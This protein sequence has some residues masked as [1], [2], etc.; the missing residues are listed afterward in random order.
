MI[1]KHSY[2]G[3][4]F[5]KLF[6]SYQS[7][8][9]TEKP[10]EQQ[11]VKV[12]SGCI[13]CPLN[14]N[15]SSVTC[16]TCKYASGINYN[17]GST[18]IKCSYQTQAKMTKEASSV[19]GVHWQNLALSTQETLDAVHSDM[20]KNICEELLWQ[21]REIGVKLAQSDLNEFSKK[22]QKESLYG[23]KLEKAARAYLAQF[24]KS[25][26][27]MISR[28]NSGALDDVFSMVNTPK[29]VVSTMS[30]P[31][32][33]DN[34]NSGCGYLGSKKNPN[35]IW[36]PDEISK[37]AQIPGTDERTKQLKEKIAE[38]KKTLKD[39][40]LKVLK[41]KLA[42]SELVSNARVHSTSTEETQSFNSNLPEN[43]MGIFGDHKEFEN[44]P[45]KTAGEQI[46]E[47]NEERT[48]KKAK[49]NATVQIKPAQNRES[50][51]WLFSNVQS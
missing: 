15:V 17:Q 4:T 35:T 19:Q 10:V 20:E 12:A 30:A 47:Q 26:K 34:M 6:N 44:I 41:E 14:G 43:A 24:N 49:E 27:P 32:V 40:Y 1:T 37:T 51:N 8:D 7:H 29:T 33:G 13:S 48:S 11:L 46:S 36:N 5:D 28:K 3:D 22:A 9:K 25:L 2:S 50:K 18:Y 23:K 38:N 21:A 31:N 42:E 39:A 16:N 45:E